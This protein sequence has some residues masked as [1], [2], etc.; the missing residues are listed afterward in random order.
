MLT[1][2]VSRV[3]DCSPEVFL[4]FVMDA[5]RYQEVDKKIRPVLWS[6]RQGN[7]SEFVFMGRMC[8]L[9]VP[10]THSR[11]VLTP[12]E[13]IDIALAPSPMN[14][15]ASLTSDFSASFVCRP[16]ASGT[17]VVRTLTFDLKLG[18]NR[19]ESRLRPRL[20]AEVEQEMDLAAAHVAGGGRD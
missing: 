10:P 17:E 5:R 6:R 13:R 12:R 8:G 11:M 18:L 4:E 16:V 2:T 9:W 7:V 19:M 20:Q 1:V 14:R 3:V 15:P